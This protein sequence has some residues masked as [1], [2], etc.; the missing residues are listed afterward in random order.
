MI[1]NSCLFISCE[2]IHTMMRILIICL[3][4][5]TASGQL[6]TATASGQAPTK[7][8]QKQPAAPSRP[9]ATQSTPAP[10]GAPT[11]RKPDETP[12]AV[13]PNDAVITVHGLC[14]ADTGVA[15]NAAVL[16]T[17]DCVIKVSR[18]QFDNLLKAFN[19]TN[20]AVPPGQLRQIA[21]AYVELLTFSEAAKAAGV[22]NT[23]AFT[24]VMRVLRLKT[25]SDLYRTQL[26]EQFRNP[27]QQEIEAYYN[28]NASK[29]ESAKLDRIYLP[30]NIPDPQA[31]PEQKDAYQKKV[32]QVVDDIQARAAK[33]EPMDK[34]QKEAYTLLGIG[35]PPPT[36]D[37]SM[38][39][40]GMFP[41]KLDQE[42]FSHKAGET[43][44]S[45]DASGYLIYRV[46]TRQAVPLDSVK[47]EIAREIS[48]HK[49]EE[50]F[51]ELTTPVHTDFNE[52]YFG[53]PTPAVPQAR[54]VPTPSR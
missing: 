37:L 16:T 29:Y 22:E 30:K 33:G 12:A 10:A 32:Q 53:P 42:I 50:K 20:Q 14:A 39:R 19:P 54:P 21:Q 41:A 25:L 7:N 4:T 52:S 5:A 13:A 3:V 48:R 27:S 8:T 6:V 46:Q 26:A 1:P 15:S 17:H 51:K 36:T 28:Q 43:F 24:E 11:L 2:R 31:T 18:E 38:A 44:R 23:P 40:H 45:D 49:M 47:D 9:A 35:A 34:L